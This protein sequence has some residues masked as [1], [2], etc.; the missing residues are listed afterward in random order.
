MYIC[1]TNILLHQSMHRIPLS[2][3]PNQYNHKTTI[4]R[5]SQHP[6]VVFFQ[7]STILFIFI[8][9]LAIINI[10]KRLDD[11]CV[12]LRFVSSSNESVDMARGNREYL[13]PVWDR[14]STFRKGA[15]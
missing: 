8:P 6:G 12:N 10:R 14:C 9:T 15:S 7:N 2:E 13:D 11:H 1:K 5:L 3:Y 4:I